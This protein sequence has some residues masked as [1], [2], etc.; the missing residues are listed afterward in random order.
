VYLRRHVT[1]ARIARAFGISVG[2]THA[3]VAA[4]TTLLAE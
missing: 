4:V 2:T 3:Y 1:L